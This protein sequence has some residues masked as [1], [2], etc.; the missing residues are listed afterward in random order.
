MRDKKEKFELFVDMDGVLCNTDK[1][2]SD[3]LYMIKGVRYDWTFN[4]NWWWT[5][6]I[7]KNEARNIL[8][9][10]D[11][12]SN[13]EPMEDAI[14]VINKLYSEGHKIYFLSTPEYNEYCAFEKNEWLVEHFEWYEENK[15][16]VLTGNKKLLDEENRLLLDDS[17][18]NLKWDKGLNICFDHL[19][20]RDFKG[21]RVKSWCDFYN[22]I[23]LIEKGE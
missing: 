17:P 4:D 9:Q 2:M 1:A 3:Y 11:F 23:Q 7:N 12:F 13:Q 8:L 19:Y 21:L 10:K 5:S 16:L 22:L 18:N 15:H 6:W 14:D 20:N